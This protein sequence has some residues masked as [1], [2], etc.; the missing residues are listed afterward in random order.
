MLFHWRF[1]LAGDSKTNHNVM[2]AR[3]PADFDLTADPPP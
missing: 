3:C 2:L 1:L